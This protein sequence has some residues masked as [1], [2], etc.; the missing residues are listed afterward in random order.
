MRKTE[1]ID[2]FLG[3]RHKLVGNIKIYLQEVRTITTG[4]VWLK[5]RATFI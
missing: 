3:P 2:H 1:E 4:F 5:M